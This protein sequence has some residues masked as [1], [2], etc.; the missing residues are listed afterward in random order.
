MFDY[1][2]GI[3]AFHVVG[4]YWDKK[5]R[6]RSFRAAFSFCILTANC[7]CYELHQENNPLCVSDV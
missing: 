7:I 2:V 4:N 3:L 1:E 5:M 6:L